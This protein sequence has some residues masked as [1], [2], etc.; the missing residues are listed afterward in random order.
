MIYREYKESD[1]SAIDDAVEPFSSSEVM[2]DKTKHGIAITGVEDGSVMACGGISYLDSDNGTVWLKMSKRCLVEPLKWAR[3]IR[4]VF[5][6]MIDSV[7]D[8]DVSTYVLSDFCRGDRVARFIGL[9]P[10]S[11]SEYYNGNTYIKYVVK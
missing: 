1:W 8:I 3:E 7:G 9:K 10:T 4:I 6:Y 2:F 11:Q 5:G